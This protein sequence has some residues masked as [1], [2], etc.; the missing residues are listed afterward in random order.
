MSFH[1]TS[2]TIF[3]RLN[4]CIFYFLTHVCILSCIS[5]FK[6]V[7]T[8]CFMHSP[9]EHYQVWALPFLLLVSLWG[10]PYICLNFHICIYLKNPNTYCSQRKKFSLLLLH[11]LF[12]SIGFTLCLLFHRSCQTGIKEKVDCVCTS[13]ALCSRQVKFSAG[14]NQRSSLQVIIG[15]KL[16][17]G[18]SS[19]YFAHV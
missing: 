15:R 9:S 10:F 13:W 18:C 7:S 3:N 8:L 1:G 6:V 12:A 5:S 14:N 19:S 2:S 11:P 17:G 16:A 4:N